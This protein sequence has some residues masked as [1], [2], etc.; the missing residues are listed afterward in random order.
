[1]GVFPEWLKHAVVIPLNK[2]GDVSYMANYRPISCYQGF[3]K[4][5]KKQC[6]VD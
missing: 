5:L 4:V 6:I 2:K 3:Q 1:M